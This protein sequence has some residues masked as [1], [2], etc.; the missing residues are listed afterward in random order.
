MNEIPAPAA[1]PQLA[2]EDFDALLAWA[3]GVADAEPWQLADGELLTELR[4][5][6]RR[7]SA[8]HARYLRLLAEVEARE[9]TLRLAS[10][11]TASWLVDNLTHSAGAA[12][13]EVALATGLARQPVVLD[14]LTQGRLSIEQAA[15]IVH[16]LSRVPEELSVEQVD[17][18]AAD[19]VGFGE[20]FGPPGLA[21]LVNRAVEAVAPEVAEDADRLALERAE[22]RARRERFLTI[23][24]DGDGGWQVRGK[25]TSLAGA[26]LVGTLK[27]IAAN[28]RRADVAAGVDTTIGQATADALVVL[29]GHYGSCNRLP[30]HGADR[31]R[32]LVSIAY[33]TL[34]G[35]L[36][37]ATLL[38]TDAALTA[39]SAR[40]LA[41]D[42]GILPVVLGGDSVPL[43]VGR[44]RRLFTGRLRTLLI[45][46]DRGCSFPGCDRPPADCEGHHRRPWWDGGRTSLANGVLVC[47]HHHHVIEP[48]PAKPPEARWCV[49]LDRR[50]NPEFSPPLR[51]GETERR[52]KQH[53]RYRT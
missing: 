49:R 11:P 47:E 35:R 50:G 20:Q 45:R 32:I 4:A 10:L 31:P 6:Q 34:V 42:A 37:S 36:G 22:A 25:L 39:Q 51:K 28:Q 16:G 53:H 40:R 21:R 23:R 48:D 46:R 52:W 38:N 2:E 43:D 18:V 1:V 33:D 12:R 13:A 14:G 8:Q 44:E 9:L 41:C 29:A 26:Q 7:L 3:G 24:P 15:T 17:S 5:A 19:L 30:R 27:A